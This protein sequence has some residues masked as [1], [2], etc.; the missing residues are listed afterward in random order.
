V[1][2]AHRLQLF[3]CFLSSR[4]DD[5]ST[6]ISNQGRGRNHTELDLGCRVDVEVRECF[7]SPEIFEWK[8]QCEPARRRGAAPSRLQCLFGLAGPVF[9]VVPKHLCSRRD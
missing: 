6:S 7:S 3:V 8:E 9:K 1:C 4:N 2:L 5:P